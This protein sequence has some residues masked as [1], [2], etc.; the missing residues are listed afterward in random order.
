MLFRSDPV[1]EADGLDR[2]L[3]EACHA[4]SGDDDRRAGAP[5]AGQGGHA[6]GLPQDP[7]RLPL[8]TVATTAPQD[9][10]LAPAKGQKAERDVP[11]DGVDGILPP[12]TQDLPQ[13]KEWREVDV[14][15]LYSTD[16][17]IERYRIVTLEDDRAFFPAYDAVLLHRADVP[18]RFPRAW[19]AIARLEG[20]LDEAR[21][22]RLN[23]AA[24]LEGLSFAEAAGLH[25]VGASEADGERGFLETLLG[26]DLWRLT[27]EHLLLVFASL[28][29][30]VAVG[31]PLGTA[32]AKWPRLAQ[33]ILAH[34]GDGLGIETGQRKPFMEFIRQLPGQIGRAHV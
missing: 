6:R 32:A 13:S 34:L 20:S 7:G 1:L 23:A 11:E 3:Q 26:P 30:S 28:A 31:V 25:Y 29:A 22:R 8:R 18:Q 9:G 24:E 19:K 12:R 5:V 21:M 27:H 16:A 15:D 10:R 17:K 14:I 4:R 2:L 33:A